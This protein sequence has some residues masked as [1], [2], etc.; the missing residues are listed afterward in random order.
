MGHLKPWQRKCSFADGGYVTLEHGL[1]I[2]HELL[3]QRVRCCDDGHALLGGCD[4]V[5]QARPSR[6][7]FRGEKH[8]D[9]R[10]VPAPTRKAHTYNAETGH[11]PK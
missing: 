2:G 5:V 9:N 8:V 10:R 6:K 4:F 1:V 7:E 11:H 3:M